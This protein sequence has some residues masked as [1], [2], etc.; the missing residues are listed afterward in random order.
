MRRQFERRGQ[1]DP[2]ARRLSETI[3]NRYAEGT[4]MRTF[5]QIIGA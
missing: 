3:A 1:P 4:V 5:R 2:H